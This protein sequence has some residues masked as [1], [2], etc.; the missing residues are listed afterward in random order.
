MRISI[1]IRKYATPYKRQNAKGNIYISG[2]TIT[3]HM[4]KGDLNGNEK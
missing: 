1:Y 2:D 3:Y 4:E